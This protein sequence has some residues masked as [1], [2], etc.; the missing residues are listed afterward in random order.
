[1]IRATIFLTALW[2]ATP[3]AAQSPL[4][5]IMPTEYPAS[6]MPGEGVK[7]FADEVRR[8]TNGRLEITP[9]FDAAAGFKSADMI[10]AVAAR[11]VVVADTFAGAAADT[12][13]LF[14]L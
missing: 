6:S 4:A 9:S 1:M 14:L 3:V 8:A 11:R 12:S 10:K 13:P 2:L 5:W 7:F